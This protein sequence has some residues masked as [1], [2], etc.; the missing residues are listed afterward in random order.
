MGRDQSPQAVETLLSRGPVGLQLNVLAGAAVLIHECFTMKAVKAKL[1][2]RHYANGIQAIRDEVPIGKEYLVDLDS[3][4]TA[5]NLN[6]D[7]CV[8]FPVEVVKVIGAPPGQCWF[9]LEL[10]EVERSVC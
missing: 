1:K 5:Q 6:A 4:R 3:K 8:I 2:A 10:L 9:P 7:N